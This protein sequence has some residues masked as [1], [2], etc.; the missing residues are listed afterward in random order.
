MRMKRGTFIIA[1]LVLG[2]SVRADQI[3]TE[4]SSS[5]HLHI[6]IEGDDTAT[7]TPSA[8]SGSD[9]R[10]ST[11]ASLNRSRL[12]KQM[13]GAAIAVPSAPEGR[14]FGDTRGTAYCHYLGD[15]DCECDEVAAEAYATGVAEGI[16]FVRRR[17]S[18]LQS[19]DELLLE[20][21]NLEDEVRR[22]HAGELPDW[23][24]GNPCKTCPSRSAVHEAIEK[25]LAKGR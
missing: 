15:T 2:A 7:P 10:F 13:E 5:G 12:G 3:T 16:A 17:Y 6:T 4:R 20:F 21:D 11:T 1:V 23:W 8:R 22:A 18:S 24:L 14:Y 25:L 9:P 19:L